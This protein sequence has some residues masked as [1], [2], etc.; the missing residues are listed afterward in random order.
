MFRPNTIKTASITNGRFSEFTLVVPFFKIALRGEVFSVV[1]V[2]FGFTCSEDE[3][4]TFT[5]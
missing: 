5:E 1:K 3:S 4:M 2:I